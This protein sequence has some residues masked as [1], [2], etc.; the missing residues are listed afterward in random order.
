M[1]SRGVC[2]T[3]TK[4]PGAWKMYNPSH[5]V[6]LEGI[7]V[8]KCSRNT[9]EKKRNSVIMPFWLFYQKQPEIYISSISLTEWNDGEANSTRRI[10]KFVTKS[11]HIAKKLTSLVN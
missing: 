9:A 11:Y 4:R 2:M 10:T 8:Q 5:L 7:G 1:V 3:K 6:N